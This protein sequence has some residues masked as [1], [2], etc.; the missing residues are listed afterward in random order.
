MGVGVVAN[1]IFN[2]I[3][4]VSSLPL[5]LSEVN[6]P[7]AS[8]EKYIQFCARIGELWIGDCGLEFLSPIWTYLWAPHVI[9]GI[10]LHYGHLGRDSSNCVREWAFGVW[11]VKLRYLYLQFELI[12]ELHIWFLLFFTLCY[13]PG[14]MTPN[15]VWKWALW[16][17]WVLSISCSLGFCPFQIFLLWQF[18]CFKV[19]SEQYTQ[20][21]LGVSIEGLGCEISVYLF[22]TWTYCELH[23]WFLW[24]FTLHGHLGRDSSNFVWK[25]ALWRLWVPSI[26]CSWG[27][28]PFQ[29]FLLWHLY[30]SR[31][32]V[33][34]TLNWSG[35]SIEG[36]GC[37]IS[38]Y[39]F[40]TWTYCE[41]HRWFLW[42]FTLHGHLGRDS[43]NFVWKWALWGYGSFP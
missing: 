6:T 28:C 13:H 10:F 11:V 43:S 36:L 23:R 32:W 5:V 1:L 20:L 26:S 18:V 8:G 38:V 33:S 25:W 22:P 19:M 17:L 41:L 7:I 29:I 34:S 3:L 4:L 9:L 39:L 37:E 42:Y 16:R 21:L 14:G 31:L 40:P 35:V 15:F 2:F 12:W 24:Y 27:F 30:P